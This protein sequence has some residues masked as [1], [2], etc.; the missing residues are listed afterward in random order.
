MQ[1]ILSQLMELKLT[2]L[3]LIRAFQ[4]LEGERVAALPA[5]TPRLSQGL[6]RTR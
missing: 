2:H 4:A 3:G 5:G 6:H 1:W